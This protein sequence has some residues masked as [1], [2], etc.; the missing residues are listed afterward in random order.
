MHRVLISNISNTKNC[1][2]LKHWFPHHCHWHSGETTI[3]SIK[4]EKCGSFLSNWCL[5]YQ[6]TPKRF[7]MGFSR[8]ISAQYLFHRKHFFLE[9]WS[10]LWKVGLSSNRKSMWSLFH[11]QFVLWRY[12][13][14][15]VEAYCFLYYRDAAMMSMR[16][17]I[18]GLTPE[19]IKNLPKE[20]LEQPTTMD[21]F[22]QTLKRV[23]KSVSKEDLEKYEK[24]MTEFGSV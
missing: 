10:Q 13:F 9:T 17:C 6:P 12:F 20:Q 2:I 11:I 16:R 8:Q 23:S 24:W 22:E 5:D 4:P 14:Q 15:Q 3:I 1:S 19:Q 18:Q 7:W 21:D